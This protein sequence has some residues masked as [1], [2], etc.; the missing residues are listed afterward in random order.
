M[1]LL[2]PF[3]PGVAVVDDALNCP[4]CWDVLSCLWCATGMDGVDRLLDLSEVDRGSLLLL[5]AE[6]DLVVLFPDCC[7]P[8]DPFA[9]P[10]AVPLADP[11]VL[12]LVLGRPF[13]AL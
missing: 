8:V 7:P 9:L 2:A 4:L 5:V 10:P 6:L 12:P 11:F 13:P 3:G 1:V